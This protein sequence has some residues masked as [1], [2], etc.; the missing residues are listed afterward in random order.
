MYSPSTYPVADAHVDILY[1]LYGG[2]DPAD[3]MASREHLE[4]GNVRILTCAVY[5]PEE[6]VAEDPWASALAMIDLF[7]ERVLGN[8]IL[9]TNLKQ[10]EAFEAERKNRAN[11]PNIT[12]GTHASPRRAFVLSLE[13]MEAIGHSLMRLRILNRLGVRLAGL[14]HNPANAVADGVGEPRGGGLTQFG[15]AIVEE[16]IRIGM[17]IDV[18]HLSERAFWQVMEQDPRPMLASHVASRRVHDHRRNLYDEQIQALIAKNG[19]IGLT[20]VPSFI[21][22][23]RPVR[24]THLLRHLE[25]LLSLGGEDTVGIGSDFD[26]IETTIEGLTHSGDFVTLRETLLQLYPASLVQKILYDNFIQFLRRL[27]SDRTPVGSG[28]TD[29]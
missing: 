28:A 7:Y 18:A 10:L 20:F 8:G 24:L 11:A 23:E 26:G 9:L 5:V 25:H 15:E 3:L 4:T 13:G 21:S 17:G 29:A 19:W 2:E 27:W 6:K 14:T 12:N 22:D 16:M 1:R